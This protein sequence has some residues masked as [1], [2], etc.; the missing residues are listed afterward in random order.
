MLA[1]PQMSILEMGNKGM[2]VHKLYKAP[3]VSYLMSVF[4]VWIPNIGLRVINGLETRHHSPSY[5]NE[6]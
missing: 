2:F 3:K 1:D 4:F 6:K 5:M